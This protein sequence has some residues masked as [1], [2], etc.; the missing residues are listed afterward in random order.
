[1]FYYWIIGVVVLI[2]LISLRVVKQYERGVRF[3]FGRFSGV[4]NPGLRL[5]LLC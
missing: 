1:M 3:L 4:M 2:I 5:I